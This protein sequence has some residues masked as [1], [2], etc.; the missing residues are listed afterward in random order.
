MNRRE[1]A[2]MKPRFLLAAAAL[3]LLST[4]LSHAGFVDLA[5]NDEAFDV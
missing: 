3:L 1:E 5:F 4:G 2:F